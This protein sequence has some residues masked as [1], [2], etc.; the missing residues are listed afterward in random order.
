M[1]FLTE[2]FLTEIQEVFEK[3]QNSINLHRSYIAIDYSNLDRNLIDQPTYQLQI[4]ELVTDCLK[5]KLLLDKVEDEITSKIS[6]SIREKATFE[7]LTEGKIEALV[8]S[9]TE[10]SMIKTLILSAKTIFEQASALKEAIVQRGFVLKTLAEL[11][12]A[13]YSA[14]NSA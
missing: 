13:G 1:A 14:K 9:N 2:S 8:N 10:I 4:A 5:V 12:I 11:W 7:K 3:L 6:L